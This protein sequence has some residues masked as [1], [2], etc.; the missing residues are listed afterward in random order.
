MELIREQKKALRKSVKEMVA[1]LDQAYCKQADRAIFQAVTGLPEYEKAKTIFCFVG[2][3]QEIDTSPILLHALSQGKRVAV[4]R[5]V[6]RG[7]MTACLIRSME[8]L[9]EGSYGILEPGEDAAV[10]E[11]EEIGL[12]VIPCCTCSRNG[13]RLGYG[14]GYYDRYL[15]RVTGTKALI[16][17]G[18]VMREDIPVE[19]HDQGMDLVVWEEGVWRRE[20]VLWRG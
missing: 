19:E 1:K 7:V 3:K 11:P 13:K 8:D 12:A 15:E 2:T 4:P 9:Q 18:K 10:I 6:A 14:G 16:C 5:C 17:R 20:Q